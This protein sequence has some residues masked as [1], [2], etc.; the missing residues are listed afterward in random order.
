MA[1]FM[2]K[3]LMPKNYFRTEIKRMRESIRQVKIQLE[4]KMQ[5]LDDLELELHAQRA[6]VSAAKK[7]PKK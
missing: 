6:K 4:K 5:Q 1:W 2:L 7:R 3:T